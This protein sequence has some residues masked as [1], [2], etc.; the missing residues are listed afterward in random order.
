MR[1]RETYRAGRRETVKQQSKYSDL[2]L[3]AIW[4]AH[5][6][7]NEEGAKKATKKTKKPK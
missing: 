6:L 2:S 3:H 5:P 7:Q 4:R 1:L